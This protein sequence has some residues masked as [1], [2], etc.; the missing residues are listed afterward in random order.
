MILAARYILFGM[1]A[2]AVPIAAQQAGSDSPVRVALRDSATRLDGPVTI[3]DLA[4][5]QG[6]S[7]SLRRRIAQLDLATSVDGR[8][9]QEVVS[10]QDVQV[11]ILMGGIRSSEFQLTGADVVTLQS[12]QFESVQRHLQTVVQD[13]LARGMQVS[14]DAVRVQFRPRTQDLLRLHEAF[15]QG[16]SFQ[17]LDHAD[18]LLGNRQIRMGILNQQSLEATVLIPASCEVEVP[19][20][21]TRRPVE[22]GETL[23]KSNTLVDVEFVRHLTSHSS[24]PADLLGRAVRRRLQARQTVR[25]TDVQP[26]SSS[27]QNDKETVIRNR[28]LVTVVAQRAGLRIK[29]VGVEAQRAG[30]VG[31]V[32]PLQN[33]LSRE[34]FLGRVRSAK[35]VELVY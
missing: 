18:R 9:E 20:L 21:V 22:I 14:P 28:D 8:T 13:H 25:A 19:V 3:G 23:D 4:D 10:R 31:D 17:P 27:Q 35:I 16:R 29:M 11:R 34:R 30:K 32:I 6:G 33:P 24:D 26:K 2:W 15:L 1:L 7:A 5:L 12:P